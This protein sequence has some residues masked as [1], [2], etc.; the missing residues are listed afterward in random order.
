MEI[1]SVI[2]ENNFQNNSSKLSEILVATFYSY[3][4]EFISILSGFYT[5]TWY[6]TIIFRGYFKRDHPI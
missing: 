1:P 4:R 3:Y 5:L 6:A 2:I